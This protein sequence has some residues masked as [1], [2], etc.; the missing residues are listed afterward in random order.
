MQML[1]INLPAPFLIESEKDGNFTA[2]KLPFLG[3]LQTVNVFNE[4]SQP[5]FYWFPLV[6]SA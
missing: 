4:E 6:R 3:N 5:P 1:N 2:V